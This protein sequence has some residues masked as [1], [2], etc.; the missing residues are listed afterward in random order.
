MKLCT[1]CNKP[2]PGYAECHS[3]RATTCAGECR[4][5]RNR[6]LW[7]ANSARR[8]ADLNGDNGLTAAREFMRKL[9]GRAI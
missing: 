8:R 1:I 6:R 4:R 5:E 3:S 7:R 2:L 9:W